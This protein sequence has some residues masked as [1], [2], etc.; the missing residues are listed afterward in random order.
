MTNNIIYIGLDVDD[1]NFHGCALEPS[2]GEALTFKCRPT[3]K[4]LI[5]QI[6]KIK[7]AFPRQPA[8]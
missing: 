3:V 8:G 1:A 4:G 5:K 2:T 6:N 7:K